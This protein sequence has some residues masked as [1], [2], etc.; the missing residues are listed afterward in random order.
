MIKKEVHM[1]PDEEEVLSALKELRSE[2][3]EV[4]EYYERRNW[5]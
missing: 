1:Y 5:K 3:N 2:R 4:A